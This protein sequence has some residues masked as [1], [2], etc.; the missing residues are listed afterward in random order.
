M[1]GLLRSSLTFH[2]R[3]DQL[4]LIY[5]GGFLVLHGFP[6]QFPF[7]HLR[8][9]NLVYQLLAL[10]MVLKLHPLYE[11][12]CLL[13]LQHVLLLLK[14][15]SCLLQLLHICI[16]RRFLQHHDVYSFLLV[17][18]VLLK[19]HRLLLKLLLFRYRLPSQLHQLLDGM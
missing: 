14:K 1:E 9:R 5:H 16:R 6:F 18:M 7:R 2:Q 3:S 12:C 10:Y 19:Q 8:F 11:R 17:Q 13:Y 15:A 4:A